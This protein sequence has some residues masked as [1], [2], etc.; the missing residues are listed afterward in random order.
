MIRSEENAGP[1]LKKLHEGKE[2]ELNFFSKLE[3]AWFV[4][5]ISLRRKSRY[6]QGVSRKAQT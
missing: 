6:A 3:N 5:H 1:S 2:R 4:A